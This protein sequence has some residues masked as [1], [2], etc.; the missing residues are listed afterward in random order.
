[1]MT[2]SRL[3]EPK[4]VRFPAALDQRIA[5]LAKRFNVSQSDLIRQAIAHQLPIWEQ[6]G[7]RLVAMDGG[8]A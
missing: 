1:M 3:Q 8:K 4:N 6:E 2:T 5:Q 7:V